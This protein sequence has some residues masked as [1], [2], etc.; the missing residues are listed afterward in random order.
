MGTNFKKSSE[1]FDKIFSPTLYTPE[2]QV[3]PLKSHDGIENFIFTVL[4][5][6]SCVLF[7]EKNQQ[8][9]CNF[10]D[11][12]GYS[13]DWDKII[14]ESKLKFNSITEYKDQYSAMIVLETLDQMISE[15]S[16]CDNKFVTGK[17]K[18]MDISTGKK[19]VIKVQL[20]F[21][22]YEQI[23]KNWIVM[24]KETE[25]S[26]FNLGFI[27]DKYKCDG[28]HYVIIKLLEC[29]YNILKQNIMIKP[30][31]YL[32]Q[33]MRMLDT[34][35]ELKNKSSL[36][37]AIINPKFD[38]CEALFKE[39]S[40]ND[41]YNIYQKRAINAG[42]GI[43]RL[44]YQTNKIL[45]IH[46]PPGTGKTHTI[47][48][49]IQNIFAN[50]GLLRIMICCP[51]N[52]A[53]DEIGI[54]LIRELKDIDNIKFV[55][56]G[57]KSQV[58]LLLHKYCLD[59][60]LE[61]VEKEDRRSFT[62]AI[63]NEANI[64]LSTLSSSQSSAMDKFRNISSKYSIRCLIVDEASQ[65]VEPELL[66]PL[67]YP[68]IS[69]VILIGDPHQLPA[70]VISQKA[71]KC[72]YDRSLF[73]RFFIHF[74]ENAENND[75]PIIQLKTQYRMH[76]EICHFPS[77]H[78]YDSELESADNCGQNPLIQIK[79]YF[80]FNIQD[81]KE[82]QTINS[83]KMNNPEANFIYKL[84]NQIFKILNIDP[85]SNVLP[86]SVG[87]ITF[88]RGQV[89]VIK[90]LF[91][92]DNNSLLANIEIGTVDSFQGKEKDII[93]LSTVRASNFGSIGFTRS[94]NRLN[95]ALTRAKSLQCICIHSNTFKQNVHW[96]A[97]LKDAQERKRI[98]QVTSSIGNDKLVSYLFILQFILFN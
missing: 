20:E 40:G 91:K 71:A 2:K 17:F 79:P 92:N 59:I 66:M 37:E 78:F 15:Y 36:Y 50:L 6:G 77:K 58:N 64:I 4:S 32:A 85:N 31:Y 33:S 83:T 68:S 73:E 46:G 88:Y 55:R 43:V 16:D 96:R 5:I 97:L 62:T 81:S 94:Q 19:F 10:I 41:N 44:P 9:M 82:A 74:K 25:T 26:K 61:K 52:N 23:F 76:K 53:I 70:T 93:I 63:M 1:N 18:K 47:T 13:I 84:L 45:L 49:L 95:V 69:K 14:V 86:V 80:V 28:I 38:T 39:V 11:R 48:R 60:L 30:F 56:I 21:S 24:I 29:D 42:F 35:D 34:L 12:Y 65:C 75:N 3:I 67:I 89:D 7:N 54:R 98:F 8:Q 57:Q 72:H 51:S 90:K 87:I 22:D 27:Y